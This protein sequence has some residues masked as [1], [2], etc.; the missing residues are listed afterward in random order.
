MHSGIQQL[1][2]RT[3]TDKEISQV[4][5]LAL[6]KDPKPPFIKLF[7]KKLPMTH[8]NLVNEAAAW[9]SVG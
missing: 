8:V 9:G 2:Q 7:E 5:N 3:G 1:L 6:Q 4:E